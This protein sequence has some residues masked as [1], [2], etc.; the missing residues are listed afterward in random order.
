MSGQ[1]RPS[2]PPASDA[3]ELPETD[4]PAG[5]AAP[6]DE[7]ENAGASTDST[8][9]SA[10]GA[11]SYS[12]RPDVP[13]PTATREVRVKR[14][15]IV[16]GAAFAL[17][18]FSLAQH[19]PAPDRPA[20]GQL[21]AGPGSPNAPGV[22]PPSPPDGGRFAPGPPPPMPGTEETPPAGKVK[23]EQKIATPSPGTTRAPTANPKM[24][25][26][27]AGGSAQRTPTPK[28]AK[29]PAKKPVRTTTPAAK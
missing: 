15:A 11:L 26:T 16:A 21:K 14:T 1:G 5:N 18:A 20:E 4:A 23:T 24:T 25:A 12:E 8:P 27:P 28:P 29:K 10:N 13:E 9:D 19:S 6:R 2:W 17:S 22:H 7:R 3:V